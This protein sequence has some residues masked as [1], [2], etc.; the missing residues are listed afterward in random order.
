MVELEL[1]SCSMP[2]NFIQLSLANA[3][4]FPSNLVDDATH[5]KKRKGDSDVLLE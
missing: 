1:Q 5:H 4:G 3:A 2:L